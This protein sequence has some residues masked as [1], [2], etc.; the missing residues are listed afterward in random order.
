MD[1]TPTIRPTPPDLESRIKTRRT[2]LIA[3]LVETKT[4]RRLETLE[5][6][7]K[8]K[9]K[10]SELDHILKWGVVDGWASVGG[11]VTQKLDRW[12][13]ESAPQLAPIKYGQS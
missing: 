6:R 9:A 2:E 4:D 8:V 5:A 7:D 13:A 11:P 12:L 3:K 1:T 10:L